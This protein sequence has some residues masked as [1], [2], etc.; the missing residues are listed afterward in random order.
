MKEAKTLKFLRLLFVVELLVGLILKIGNY[1][2][3]KLILKI[4]SF[5]HIDN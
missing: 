2:G 1:S 3:Q 4:S 5:L